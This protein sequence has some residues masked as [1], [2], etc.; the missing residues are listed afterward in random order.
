MKYAIL[1]EKTGLWVK[2]NFTHRIDLEV[3][4]ILYPKFRFLPIDETLHG[5]KF[6]MDKTKERKYISGIKGVR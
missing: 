2:M 3:F 5:H 6:I 4:K 1:N